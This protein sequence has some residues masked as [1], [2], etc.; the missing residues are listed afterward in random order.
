[1]R[2]FSIRFA[3][4]IIAL[5]AVIYIAGGV[6]A[7]SWQSI[8]AAGLVLGLLNAFLKPIILLLTLPLN[9]VSLGLFTLIVNGF[10]FYMTSKFVKGFNI[11]DFWSAFWAALLF[12]AI[13]FFLNML[14]LPK[15]SIRSRPD[16]AYYSEE[17]KYDDVIDVEGEVDEAKEDNGEKDE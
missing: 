11:V 12:S 15:I 16:D 8:V 10:L 5:F 1:M 2:D 14:L 17:P 6:S 3:I 13:S 9:I 4:N 7:D